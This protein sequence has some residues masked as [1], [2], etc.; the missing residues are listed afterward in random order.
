[1]FI[2]I[3]RRIL[4]C[5][6][7]VLRD[8]VGIIKS[9]LDPVEAAGSSTN[10]SSFKSAIAKRGQWISPVNP[11]ATLGVQNANLIKAEEARIAAIM[12]R[13]EQHASE[14]R[15]REFKRAQEK[16]RVEEAY[17]LRLEAVDAEIR[18]AEES[19]IEEEARLDAELEVVTA[20]KESDLT[21][22][23]ADK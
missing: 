20:E 16:E 1:M 9:D 22:G 15:E 17:R 4:K 19:E 18:E 6:P 11:F 2:P 3:L 5:S 8:L 23:M 13:K 14:L 12:A 21:A 10:Q 7:K